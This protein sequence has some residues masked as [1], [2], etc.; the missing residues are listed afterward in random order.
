MQKHILNIQTEYEERHYATSLKVAGSIPGEVI[1]CF[2]I[3]VA[4]G[5][6]QLVT[7]MSMRNLLRNK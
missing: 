5:L 1:D 4:L 3:Y 6:T 7:E 2:L